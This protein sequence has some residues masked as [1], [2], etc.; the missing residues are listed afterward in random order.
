MTW[1]LFVPLLTASASLFLCLSAAANPN[2]NNQPNNHQL[3][4]KLQEAAH[5]AE[6]GSGARD[7]RDQLRL[8]GADSQAGESA[9]VVIAAHRGVCARVVIG[10]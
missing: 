2:N 3:T 5:H 6:P 1:L 4:T 7:C 9:C 8:R 10:L